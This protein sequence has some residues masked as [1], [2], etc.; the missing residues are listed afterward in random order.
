MIIEINNQGT[1][2]ARSFYLFFSFT[3]RGIN[4]TPLEDARQM[5]QDCHHR[6]LWVSDWCLWNTCAL[7]KLHIC[8]SL[9]PAHLTQGSWPWMIW[10]T[11]FLKLM[12]KYTRELI[13]TV[14]WRIKL[15]PC[16]PLLRCPSRVLSL[17]SSRP[18][19][20]LSFNI[21]YTSMLVWALIFNLLFPFLTF[22]FCLP[23][24]CPCTTIIHA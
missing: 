11:I 13:W 4:K 6:Q 23:F 15:H 16:F 12:I 24:H 7:G 8:R 22:L 2:E 10:L 5:M 17:S 9:S 3:F 14:L 20:S 19:G 21:T 18:N 1:D